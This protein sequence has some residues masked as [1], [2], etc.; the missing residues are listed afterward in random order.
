MV[1]PVLDKAADALRCLGIVPKTSRPECPMLFFPSLTLYLLTCHIAFL[2]TG[3]ALFYLGVSECIYSWVILE[4][5]RAESLVDLL[6]WVFKDPWNS[7]YV[8]IF[9]DRRE[10]I[11]RGKYSESKT[12]NFPP[13]HGSGIS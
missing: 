12:W 7:L 8:I 4:F 1:I 13:F 10:E 11:D 6:A 3:S 9:Y 2:L 5:Q